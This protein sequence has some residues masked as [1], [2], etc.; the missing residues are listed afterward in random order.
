[1]QLQRMLQPGQV[2]IRQVIPGVAQPVF[3]AV[4]L[5]PGQMLPGQIPGQAIG[6]PGLP[7]QALQAGVRP[8]MLYTLFFYFL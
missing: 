5:Q 4:T 3:R 6:V 7:G 1:M 2:L 8:G